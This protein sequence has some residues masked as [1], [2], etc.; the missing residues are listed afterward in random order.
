MRDELIDDIVLELLD[1][2][3]EYPI[4]KRETVREEMEVRIGYLVVYH[5]TY[6]HQ[7][8]HVIKVMEGNPY[9]TNGDI[10]DFSG[11]VYR[12]HQFMEAKKDCAQGQLYL[13][14]HILLDEIM[15]EIYKIFREF[16]LLGNDLF[17]PKMKFILNDLQLGLSTK[18]E[19]AIHDF[20]SDDGTLFW[21]SNQLDGNN[22]IARQFH[23]IWITLNSVY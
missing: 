2:F 17:N 13:M 23:G 22:G 19:W 20:E 18:N 11:R 12:A 5:T 21:I 8:D 4:S 6:E 7:V 15:E 9:F 10:D 3:G 16:V 1:I 14:Y